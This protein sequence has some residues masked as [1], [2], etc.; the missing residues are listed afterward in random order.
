VLEAIS[1][2]ATEV[3]EQA[4]AMLE[5]WSARL[6]ADHAAEIRE[7]WANLAAS[8]RPRAERLVE[9]LCRSLP[10]RADATVT[11][12]DPESKIQGLLEEAGGI[13]ASWRERAGVDAAIQAVRAGRVPGP[14]E[15][16][17][18][19]ARVLTGVAPI[20]PIQSVDEL[21]DAVAHAVETMDSA[22]ELER[23]LDGISRLCDQRPPDFHR[24]SDPLVKRLSDSHAVDEFSR[25]LA[26]RMSESFYQ[27]L[28]VW[29]C[30]PWP[31]SRYNPI[32]LHRFFDGRVQELIQRVVQRRAQPLLAAPTHEGGWIDPVVLV[33]RLAALFQ[34]GDE[35][36]SFDLI[37]A[38]LR[39]AP[40]GRQEA[41]AAAGELPGHV[42]RA[43]RWCLGSEEGPNAED[44]SHTSLWLAAGR[45]RYPTGT[46]EDLRVLM[47]GKDQPDAFVPARYVWKPQTRPDTSL[48]WPHDFY[49]IAMA[50][51]PE[52]LL[53]GGITVWPTVAL[54]LRHEHVQ[55]V[56]AWQCGFLTTWRIGMIS[57][58]W[59]LCLDPFLV[60]GVYAL[61]QRLDMPASTLA[62]NHAFLRPW[63]E[64]DRPWSELACLAVWLG[65]VSKDADSRQVA[66]DALIEAVGDGRANPA[67][68]A[69]VLARLVPG[70]WVKL[71][72]VA[73]ALGETA[74]LSPLHSW[75]A[76]E[77]LQ[78]L[79]ARLAQLPRDAHF[80]LSLLREL[81]VDLGTVLPPP[82]RMC[83]ETLEGSSKTA[84]MARALLNLRPA[85]DPTK[86]RFAAI[87]AMEAR[88]ARARRW[89]S[90][91][92]G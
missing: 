44:G 14:L 83:L 34:N 73:D 28:M 72:R 17:L 37:Q 42:G 2:P 25:L 26:D 47:I 35:P 36:R 85:S 1:H 54:H 6:H 90:A 10:A 92:D 89:S 84:K 79:L 51:E 69:D 24:R 67:A 49:P 77:T 57:Q 70:G 71:N 33:K 52:P 8:V 50:V 81:L 15:F 46:L 45:A 5:S 56:P 13:D 76:A 64:P 86:L 23:I 21:L 63:L 59:P 40:D 11:D 31:A 91:G 65:L 12:S 48:R 68:M 18:L 60:G 30:G 61:G 41:L 87:Q 74:R 7:R 58:I 62:P 32:A 4:V 53:D 19:E 22:D 39:L 78:E 20:A 75:F 9:E 88:I 3:Q 55:H 16:D 29:L 43:V 66:L 82:S 38:I 27:L 80:V